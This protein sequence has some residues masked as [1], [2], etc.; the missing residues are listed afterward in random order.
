ME[1][2]QLEAFT[3]VVDCKSF[4]KAAKQLYLTQPTVSAHIA[5]LEKELDTRLIVRTTK[6]LNITTQGYQLY[7]YAM[8]MLKIRDNIMN[9]FTGS[10]KKIIELGASTIPSSYILPEV[11]SAFSHLNP[12]I[13]F[14]A[15]L[16]DSMGVIE[17][18]QNDS[19]DFGMV[20]TTIDDADLIFLP[21]LEDELVIVTPVTPHYLQ[22]EKEKADFSQMIS[23][24]FILREKGSGTKKEI[25]KYFERKKI[26]VSN[27]NVV[28]RMN[29]LEAVKKSIVGGLGISILSAKSIQELKNSRQVI[30][31]PLDK[32]APKRQL[33]IV[34]KREHNLMPHI[35]QFIQFVRNYYQ[36]H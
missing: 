29:D 9:E 30:I 27:I 7:D 20:G 10:H 19:L 18:V 35:R 24:P 2:K 21:F 28:A 14:H 5:A 34:Y 6:K 1:L 26:P 32:P 17:Q 4:S 8:A 36:P 22:L 13:Y 11:L 15:R 33:Y 25:D 23:E 31:F 3:A 16:S 12:D